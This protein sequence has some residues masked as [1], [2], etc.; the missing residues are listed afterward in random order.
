MST[1]SDPTVIVGPPQARAGQS[2]GA[3]ARKDSTN[4]HKGIAMTGKDLLVAAGAAF[5]LAFAASASAQQLKLSDGVVKIGVLTD[6]SSLYA[7]P[8]GAGAVEAVKMA[9]EDFTKAN[10][11]IKVE[12]VYADHQ[13]KADVASTKAREWYDRDKVDMINDLITSSV[14]LAVSATANEKKKIAISNGAAVSRL[15]GD[16]CNPYTI[17]YTYDTVA[18][19]NGTGNAV[20]KQGGDTWFFIVADY[21][22][23]HQMEKDIS[24]IVR[25]GG[26]KVVGSVRHPLNASDFSSFILQA[27]GSGAKIIGLA[28]AGGDF[29]NSIKAAHDFGLLKSGKQ[30]LAG[31]VVFINDIHS[32]GLQTAQGLL[33]TTGFYWDLNAETR[34]WS[35]RF[36]ERMKRMPSMV[37]AGDYSSTMHYLNAVKAAGTDD[38]DAVMKKMRETPVNDFFAKNGKIRE[39]G[40]MVHEMYLV[41]VKTPAESKRP[42]DYYKLVAPIPGDEAFLP[43]AKS[44]CPLVKK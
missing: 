41:Q 30:K 29:V 10:P 37:Q 25:A 1:L 3:L 32:L 14:A 20:V 12:V 27:Q 19:A 11:G 16:A 33:L 24:E 34:A 2:R 18:I 9:A 7:D 8:S 13:N 23:G 36:F 22:Y 39:D 21:A 40:R 31:T 28:N 43:L 15:T 5:C 38:T 4:A 44:S 42:W 26:G 17:H 35:Q 6:M